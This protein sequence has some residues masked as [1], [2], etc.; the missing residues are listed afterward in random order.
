MKKLPLWHIAMALTVM[1]EAKTTDIK[2]RN[3]NDNGIKGKI[4]QRI[5]KSEADNVIGYKRLTKKIDH[6]KNIIEAFKNS[7]VIEGR[8]TNTLKMML[9]NEEK[10][11]AMWKSRKKAMEM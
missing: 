2:Y 9:D 11:M 5:K 8:T 1:E 10:I 6:Q 4:T 3:V 7:I